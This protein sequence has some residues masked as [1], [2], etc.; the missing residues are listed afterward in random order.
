MKE[1]N[2]PVIDKKNEAEQF[3][4]FK[5]NKRM[6]IA[7]E[8]LLKM[9]YDYLTPTAEREMLK[10]ICQN[11]NGIALGAVVIHPVFVKACV[12]FLGEDPKVS[13]IAAISYPHGLDTTAVKVEAVKLA[14]KDG[15]DEVEVYAPMSIIKDGNW[16]YF[17]RECKKLK[18]ACKIRALRIV[19]DCTY[20]TDKELIK[21]CNVASDA[22]VNCVRLNSA[23]HEIISEVKQG[24]KGKCLIKADIAGNTA[25][26]KNF[27]AAGAD[28]VNCYSAIEMASSV[29]AE[30][31]QD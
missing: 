9:E 16:Q 6:Q 28:Y 7:K 8:N 27:C 30:V 5:K 14:V 15:V 10:N 29:L 4:E 18:K 19:V 12:G 23:V 22:G 2:I 26:F 31:G 25:E 21:I 1:I 24:V 17:K 13:L 11:A 20:F 3:D